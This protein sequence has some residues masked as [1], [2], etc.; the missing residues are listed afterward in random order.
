MS[1][2]AFEVISSDGAARAGVLRMERGS[3][4]VYTG[5]VF[6]GAY[7]WASWFYDFMVNRRRALTPEA[8][9]HRLTGLPAAT[10]GL[11]DR[12]AIRAG[13]AADIAIFDPAKFRATATTATLFG[14]PW[15]TSAQ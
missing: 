14:F 12:G 5:S 9:I 6:H 15:F 3:V 7:T 8:A 11:S 10:L 4:L 1:R 2:F 13:A